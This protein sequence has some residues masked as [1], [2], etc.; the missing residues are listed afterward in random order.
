MLADGTKVPLGVWCGS[1]ENHVVT[2]ELMQDLIKRGLRV[3]APLLFVID[4]GK[5]IRKALKDVFGDRAVV[6]RCQV[7]KARNVR[8]HLP[9]ERRAYVRRQ[10]RDAYKRTKTVKPVVAHRIVT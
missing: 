8:D 7:H 1:T 4:G 3:D 10:M 5:G 6:Q 9:H 2:G